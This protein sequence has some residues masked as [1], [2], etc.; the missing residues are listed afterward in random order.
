MLAACLAQAMEQCCRVRKPLP[1]PSRFP[2]FPTGLV[3][4]GA[5]PSSVHALS[6]AA[7]GAGALEALANL[8]RVGVPDMVRGDP[9]RTS[10]PLRGGEAEGHRRLKEYLYGR[11]ELGSLS[12]QDAD[13]DGAATGQRHTSR[14]A[15]APD[16][17]QAHDR[18]RG[19]CSSSGTADDKT[20]EAQRQAATGTSHAA[21]TTGHADQADAAP[22]AVEAATLGE[23][24]V[25]EARGEA[26]GVRPPIHSFRETRMGAVGVDNS[27]KVSA[28]LASGCLSPRMVHAAV[29]A[30]REAHGEDTGHSWVVM[31]LTIRS[32][33]DRC[34]AHPDWFPAAC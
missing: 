20:C 6:E 11:A 7:G 5:L 31:H 33:P 22:Q 26:A 28:Y 23:S 13:Q 21:E 18:Q 3:S 4:A 29:A 25:Q 24:Q 10:F 19:S 34:A 2:P 30:A 9:M 14:T 1:A 27:L 12:L 15:P 32:S 16:A 8:T 17:A